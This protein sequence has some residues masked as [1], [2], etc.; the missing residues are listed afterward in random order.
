MPVPV[1]RRQ[2]VDYDT[3]K[4][5]GGWD[6]LTPK[7]SLSPG[8]LLDVT[9][10]EMAS[11]PGG[12]YSRIGGYERYDGRSRPSDA[13]YTVVQVGSFTNTPTVGQTLTGFTSTATGTIAALGSNFMILTKVVG[14]FTNTEVV[15]VG[16]TTIGT[17]VPTTT[18]FTAMQDAQYTQAA[19]DIYRA[20]IGAVPG[21]GP[22]RGVVGLT[23]SGSDKVYA[24]RDNAGGTAVDIY[25][26]STS[27]WTS[28][29]LFYEISFTAGAVATPADGATLTQGGVTATVQ[30]V[31]LQSGAWTGAGAGRLIIT[32]PSGGNFAAGAATLSGGATCTLAGIQTA[33]TISP[34]GRFQFAIGN[35][36]GQTESV[37][38]Y[39]IDG[40]NRGFEFDGT[41]YVPITTGTSTDVP[42]HVA[43]FQ[44][45]V[46]FS[47]RS[48]IIHSGPGTPFIWTAGGGASE[49]ACGNTVTN[50]VPQPGGTSTGALGIT[51]TDNYYTL[52]GSGVANWSL[53]GLN[54]GIG[55][56]P[57]TAQLL[58]Q[59]YWL[60]DAGVINLKTSQAY[61]NF[62]T[63][64]LTQ[65]INTFMSNQRSLVA[66]SVICHGKSQYRLYFTDGQGLYLTIANGKFLGATKVSFPTA[67]Y[68][69]W[70]AERSDFTERIFVGA[71]TGGYVYEVDRGS[72]F[73]GAAIEASLV[74]NWNFARSPRILKRY[75]KLSLELQGN[76]YAAIN[77]GYSLGYNTSRRMQPVT[78]AVTSNFAGVP[79][80]DT[81]V[82]DAFTW[83]GSTLSPSEI[84]LRGSAENI[85]PTISC[86]TN[87]IQPFTVN[88]MIFNISGRRGIR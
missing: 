7:L 59:G 20:D 35:L 79:R 55:G 47:F 28:V 1:A 16:A 82:W 29:P 21:S 31:C 85:Q 46:F 30:R 10:F 37:R 36:A 51:T 64:S 81:F 72:S 71:A 13:S 22:V 60:D 9:N 39:G 3:V 41:T 57:R 87:Y 2:P 48:S 12:G 26:A 74:F 67:V 73:D 33:I 52:Y 50:F 49:I 45:Q 83:D 17:A 70:S 88:S 58:N 4:M 56:I 34:G 15:K 63:S 23:V 43:I 77:F 40:V 42:S 54:A 84:Q 62:M 66:D 18:V 69:A 86:G 76:F 61:G 14:T 53:V 80:W 6:Q 27:G 24:F 8:A 65:H 68:C 32:A 5:I 11:V 38:A 19:A 44:K 78:Q 25:V 75:R